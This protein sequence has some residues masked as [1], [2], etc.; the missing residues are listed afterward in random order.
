MAIGTATLASAAGAT[1]IGTRSSA[2]GLNP[3]AIGRADLDYAATTV[4][5]GAT[6]RIAIGSNVK[7]SDKSTSSVGLGAN[8]TVTAPNA[9]GL[10]V[11]ARAGGTHGVG[12]IG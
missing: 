4:G 12:A 9:G 3:L 7:V 8:V 6:K 5:A 10:G 2:G 1:A 11:S